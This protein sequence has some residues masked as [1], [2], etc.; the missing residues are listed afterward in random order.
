[1]GDDIW[2]KKNTHSTTQINNILIYSF[3]IFNSNFNIY[4][5]FKVLFSFKILQNRI[6][7]LDTQLVVQK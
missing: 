5:Q 4:F 7:R 3:C 6:H 1:M 2:I